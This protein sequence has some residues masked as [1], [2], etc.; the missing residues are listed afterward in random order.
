MQRGLKIL[1]IFVF[2]NLIIGQLFYQSYS[3]KILSGQ[4]SIKSIITIFVTG[5][6]GFAGT[7]KEAVFYVL[8]PISYLLLLSSILVIGY[9]SYKYIFHVG[10]ALFLVCIYILDI[11]GL[12]SANLELLTVGLLGVILGYMSIEK[13][14]KFVSHSYM[15]VAA[16]V[17]YTIAITIWN[18]VY[19]LQV[20]GVCL[21]LM[22]IY[23]L[24]AKTG[25]PGRAR[26]HIMLLGQY[27]LFG[28]ITQIAV[29]QLLYRRLSN[30]EL[31]AGEL[32]M[33]FV[34]A[35]ALTMISVELIDRARAKSTAV[36]AL[37]KGV[38]A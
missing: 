33:T 7:G 34:G 29:L 10:C 1:G 8:V 21:S 38:F 27:S 16:Y 30:F 32:L 2:L 36:N 26:R 3:G 22:L 6:V 24:G 35:F 14:N 37:Y 5:N 31:G 13:I 4:W 25:E 12:Q 28:Y 23:L 9:Q 17:C 20:V 11:K 15:L 18:V 19:P